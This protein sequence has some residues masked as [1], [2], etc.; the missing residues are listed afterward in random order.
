MFRTI[1]LLTAA[2]LFMLTDTVIAEEGDIGLG[3]ILGEPTGFSG[4]LWTGEDSAVCGAVAWSIADDTRLLH[5]HADW[6]RHNRTVLMRAF[7]VRQGELPLYYGLGGRVRFDDDTRVGVRFVVGVDYIFEQA[8]LDIF[9]E[10]APVMDLLPKTT[11]NGNVA[12]GVRF[13]F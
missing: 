7:D 9:Y 11:L 13:W 10:I 1:S 3:I 5:V 6:V 2:L 8:P 4:K 12:I